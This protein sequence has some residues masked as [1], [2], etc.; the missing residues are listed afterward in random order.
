M[1][2]KSTKKGQAKQDLFNFD[3]EIVIGV[4]KIEEPK[5]K[6]NKNKNKKK[7]LNKAKANKPNKKIDIKKEKR[8]KRIFSFIKWV[9]IIT[10][11]VGGLLALMLSPLFKIEKI[12]VEVNSRLSAEDIISLSQIEN[13]QNLFLVNNNNAIKNIKTNP[14]IEKIKI[15]KKL[16]DHIQIVVKERKA[17]YSLKCNETYMYINNQGY[18]LEEA[19]TANGLPEIISYKTSI[20]DMKVGNRLSIEDLE[21][22]GTILKI[23]EL[24]NSNEIGNLITSIDIGAKNDIIL[25]LDSEGKI[26]H[27]GNSSDIDTKMMYIKVIL[28]EEKGVNGEIIIDGNSTSEKVIFRENI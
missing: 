1:K 2:K 9:L 7:K 16:P 20:D 24:A 4:T 25:N 11:V 5:K 17:T 3:N 6:K 27:L 21:T 18:I 10:I 23:M 28:D 26:V 22:L 13:G 14:Y 15:N 19:E 12:T 8:K